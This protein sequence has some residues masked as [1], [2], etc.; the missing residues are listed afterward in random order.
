MVKFEF[1][2][3]AMGVRFPLLA[4]IGDLHNGSAGVFEALCRGSIPL[5]PAI[6]MKYNIAVGLTILAG[7]AVS[8]AYGMLAGV[9]VNLALFLIV[10]KF[11][12]KD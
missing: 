6:F 2:K 4:P 11:S 1:S 12:T 7:L 8:V 9:A 10:E 5:S 3:L